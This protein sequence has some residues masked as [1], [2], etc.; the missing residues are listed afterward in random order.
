MKCFT[1]IHIDL[2]VLLSTS[3]V[4][5]G[6]CSHEVKRHLLLGR[7]AMT[8]LDSTLK[9]RDITITTLT[10]SAQSKLWFFQWSHRNVR[11]GP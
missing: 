1:M 9:G 8:N 2:Q 11:I 4:S 3:G 6:D 7:A 5:D 10:E